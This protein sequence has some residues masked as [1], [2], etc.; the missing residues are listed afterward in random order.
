MTMESNMVY[1]VLIEVQRRE[2]LDIGGGRIFV[3]LWP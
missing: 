3:S 1:L 2:T